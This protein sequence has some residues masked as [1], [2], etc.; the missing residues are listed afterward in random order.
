[1]ARALFREAFR[2]AC[3]PKKDNLADSLLKSE[4][5][6]EAK[7]ERMFLSILNRMPTAEDREQFGKYLDVDAK[8]TKVA[9]QRIS[10]AI[11]VL[12]SSSE[13]RFNK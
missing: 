12:V 8:D 2:N 6:R 9:T 11:W 10:E 5:G 7:I 1:M 3:S 4:E 13:F